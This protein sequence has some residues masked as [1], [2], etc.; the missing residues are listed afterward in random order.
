MQKPVSQPAFVSFKEDVDSYSNCTIMDEEARKLR[1]IA[2]LEK[3][4]ND[5]ILQELENVID[6]NTVPIGEKKSFAEFAGT[7]TDEEANEWLKNIEEGCEQINP[8]DWK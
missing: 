6:K 2:K 4:H 7:L 8:D 3:I 1:I 5:A